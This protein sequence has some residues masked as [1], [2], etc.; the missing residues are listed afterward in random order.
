LSF[1]FY[2]YTHTEVNQVTMGV[3]PW[4]SDSRVQSL[5]FFLLF[6]YKKK[7]QCEGR[8]IYFNFKKLYMGV[9]E[10]TQQLRALVP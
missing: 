1:P 7:W 5:L 2:K 3:R 6:F 9:G 10:L 4:L 8:K